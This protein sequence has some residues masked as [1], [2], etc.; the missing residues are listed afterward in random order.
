MSRVSRAGRSTPGVMLG[1]GKVSHPPSWLGLGVHPLPTL[2]ACVGLGSTLAT[3]AGVR[4][5]DRSF[6]AEGRLGP[7]CH[8]VSGEG[9]VV[10]V[11]LTIFHIVS[12]LLVCTHKKNKH[13]FIALLSRLG[14]KPLFLSHLER[15]Y[16]RQQ[17]RSNGN[18]YA[19][20]IQSGPR[21]GQRKEKEAWAPYMWNRRVP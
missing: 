5:W 20:L 1:M 15:E 11:V 4:H 10:A 7:F 12:D 14:L 16:P 2:D 19:S 13:L 18:V 6:G 9:V 8:D 17:P 21:I 3:G